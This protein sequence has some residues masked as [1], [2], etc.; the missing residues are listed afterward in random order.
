MAALSKKCF[1]K[2]CVCATCVGKCGLCYVSDAMC[3]KGKGRCGNYKYMD[4]ETY[5]SVYS[6][7]H[8]LVDEETYKGG[9]K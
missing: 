2:R 8:N 6:W 5:K 4:Y 7:S 3:R 1:E 9:T